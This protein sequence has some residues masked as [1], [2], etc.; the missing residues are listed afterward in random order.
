MRLSVAA[1]IRTDHRRCV[2]RF[3]IMGVHA[4]RIAEDVPGGR[5]AEHG[6]IGFGR[7]ATHI[8]RFS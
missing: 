3:G 4:G 8:H 1:G 2:G 5:L 6:D 7:G